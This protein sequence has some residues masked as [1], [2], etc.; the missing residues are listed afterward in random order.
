MIIQKQ[1]CK[2]DV[3]IDKTIEYYREHS[4]CDCSACRNFY[5]QAATALP[6]LNAFL[7]ELG[8]DVSRPDE[9]ASDASDYTVDYYFVAYTVSGKV[10]ECDKYE[11]DIQEGNLF[12]SIVIGDHYIPNEQKNEYFVIS[13]YGIKLPWVLDEPLPDAVPTNNFFSKIKKIFKKSKR[14]D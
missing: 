13:V 11:I 12:L 4:L 8:V 2:M 1:D 14:T 5:K 3:D 6:T 7:S 9:S 10:L